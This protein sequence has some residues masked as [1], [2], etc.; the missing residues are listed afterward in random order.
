MATQT[1]K[2]GNGAGRV[3]FDARQVTNG[4]API[5]EM[6]RPY[7]PDLVHE[8][9]RTLEADLTAA[10]TRCRTLL[11][12]LRATAG[13]PTLDTTTIAVVTDRIG[14]AVK[15]ARLCEE[16]GAVAAVRWARDGDGMIYGIEF[17]LVRG[18]DAGGSTPP[19][20]DLD[21]DV[22]ARAYSV[23]AVGGMAVAGEE[24]GP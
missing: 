1:K 15:M 7:P 18:K 13:A 16:T 21:A 5:V 12:L 10:R 17:A 22:D 14:P 24:G 20:A 4:A 9:L 3:D 23:A 8:R 6:A 11:R 2:I 19:N